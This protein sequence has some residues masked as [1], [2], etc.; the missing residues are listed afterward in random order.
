[1]KLKEW[2][3]NNRSLFLRSDLNFL[4]KSLFNREPW[5]VFLEGYFLVPKEID[6]LENI[7]KLYLKG[8][9][10]PFLIG[11][12]VF[13]GLTFSVSPY[14]FI[15]R[16]DTEVIIEKA[17]E[18]INK[19]NLGMILDL[20]CG[21]SCIAVAIDKYTNKDLR[22]FASDVSWD[23]LRISRKNLRYHNSSVR[24]IN[25]D[26]FSG[27]KKNVFD[28]V[29]CN[30]PYVETTS[31]KGSLEYE[32]RTALEAGDDGLHFI[33]KILN[34]AHLYLRSGG[35]M[36]IEFGYN[37]KEPVYSLVQ[38][39]YLYEIVEWIKDYS[40]HTRGVILKRR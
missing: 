34:Q 8:L 10:L 39:L 36:I 4:I 40:S 6:C 27:F 12:E 5:A 25:T 26:L 21:T 24:L 33:K 32:P 30:P 13:F 23:A 37:H 3:D 22:I 7:K 14:V 19:K 29:V 1:M 16:Q 11:R 15:P 35:Y 18:L 2:V 17:L 28:L 38:D 9:P 31:I 20:G